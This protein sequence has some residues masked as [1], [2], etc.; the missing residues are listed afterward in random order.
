MTYQHPT[1]TSRLTADPAWMGTQELH[2][3]ATPRQV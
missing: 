2:W 1:V 3:H